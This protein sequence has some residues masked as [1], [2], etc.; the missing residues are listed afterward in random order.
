VEWL[1]PVAPECR[2]RA[3]RLA[4]HGV[5]EERPAFRGL[6][7]EPVLGLQPVRVDHPERPRRTGAVDLLPD[8]Q[9]RVV[10]A[11]SQRARRGGD[12]GRPDAAEVGE[13]RGHPLRAGGHESLVAIPDLHPS[14]RESRRP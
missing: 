1:D 13:E 14:T 2:E 9:P 10:A 5:A 12:V 4:F 6:E 7:L 11:A 8:H 3:D